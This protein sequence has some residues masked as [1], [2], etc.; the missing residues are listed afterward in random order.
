MEEAYVA[1]IVQQTVKL[2]GCGQAE[3][4]MMA[5]AA[6]VQIGSRLKNG[7]ELQVC[8]AEL[9]SAGTLWTLSLLAA[10]SAGTGV[11]AY[12]AGDVRVQRRSAADAAA[13]AEIL[14]RQ[15][16]RILAPYLTDSAFEFRG[17]DG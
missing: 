14:R 12:S 10:A 9:V 2:A 8:T 15:A 6:C 16:E 17:V 13:G 5:R 11:S 4:E 7:A 3:A 1:E